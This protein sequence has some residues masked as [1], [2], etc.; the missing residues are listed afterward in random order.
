M[1]YELNFNAIKEEKTIV[2]G[3]EGK[4]AV[5]LVGFDVK[6]DKNGNPNY[7]FKFGCVDFPEQVIN[8]NCG[9]S[10]YKRAV[11]GIAVQLGFELHA[12][13]SDPEILKKATKEQFYLWKTSDG[14]INFYDRDENQTEEAPDLE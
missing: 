2:G 11:S 3:L 5:K 6:P 14:Y 8:Y 4:L 12:Q 1:S 9:R 13:D 10:F 7:Q